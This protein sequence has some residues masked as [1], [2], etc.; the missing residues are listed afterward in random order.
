MPKLSLRTGAFSFKEKK[1]SSL[2]DVNLDYHTD[3]DTARARIDKISMT[4]LIQESISKKHPSFQQIELENPVIFASLRPGAKMDDPA[5][6]EK[7][8]QFETGLFRLNNGKINFALHNEN[9]S[10]QY[11]TEYLDI[12]VNDI[13]I[14]KEKAALSVGPFN[15]LSKMFYVNINDSIEL[16]NEKGKFEMAGT[17]LQLGSETGH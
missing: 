14:G 17:G 9:K 8:F 3:K 12:Y 4:P 6:D 15:M 13:R 1:P 11:K 16:Y 10:V 2:N 5:D 7:K